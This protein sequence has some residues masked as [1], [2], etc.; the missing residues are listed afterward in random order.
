M[1]A[2]KNQG[3]LQVAAALLMLLVVIGV[4]GMAV[5]PKGVYVISEVGV[6]PFSPGM[7]KAAALDRVNGVKTIRELTT[8]SPA[9]RSL[10]TTRKGFS[11]TPEMADS[12]A[13][14]LMDRQ[15]GIYWLRFAGSHV[16][17]VLFLNDPDRE[18]QK[19]FLAAVCDP[20]FLNMPADYLSTRTDYPVFPR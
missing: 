20:E 8:C 5:R 6:K 7:E 11:M 10:L 12:R 17:L 16:D 2:K 1:S 18:D 15:K 9:S 19:A 14:T 3:K 13:W 4:E